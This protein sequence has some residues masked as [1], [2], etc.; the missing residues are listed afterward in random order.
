MPMQFNVIYKIFK[1]NCLHTQKLVHTHHSIHTK[2]GEDD[3]WLHP[4]FASISYEWQTRFPSTQYETCLQTYHTNINLKILNFNPYI[5]FTQKQKKKWFT[6]Y[7]YLLLLMG[8]ST[9]NGPFIIWNSFYN[10]NEFNPLYV[11]LHVVC[12]IQ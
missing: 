5:N 2:G 4:N 10:S 7:S 9:F 6:I 3:Q 12:K 1:S 11:M 8:L